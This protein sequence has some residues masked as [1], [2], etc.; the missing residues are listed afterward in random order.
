MDVIVY[1]EDKLLQVLK[2]RPH[3]EKYLVNISPGG[4]QM[5]QMNHDSN[6]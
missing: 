4:T 5:W 3:A 2:L 6:T 1:G